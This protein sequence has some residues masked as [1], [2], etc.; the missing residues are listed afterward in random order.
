MTHADT[1][2]ALI[3]IPLIGAIALGGIFSVRIARVLAC[4]LW[5]VDTPAVVLRF[6]HSAPSSTF[7]SSGRHTSPGAT[8]VTICLNPP[9]LP[10]F[11]PLDVDLR[12]R[13]EAAA[14]E[15]P[16]DDPLSR[17]GVADID[18]AGLYP[19]KHIQVRAWGRRFTLPAEQE[20]GLLEWLLLPESVITAGLLAV[21]LVIVRRTRPRPART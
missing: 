2:K 13:A 3:A 19:G 11:G 20:R 16:C 1:R 8:S 14:A 12:M 4:A 5:G 17:D 9:P 6:D 18:R 10:T 7:G 21:T 15:R